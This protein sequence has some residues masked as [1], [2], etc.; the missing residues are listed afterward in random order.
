MESENNNHA[1]ILK[2]IVPNHYT[3]IEFKFGKDWAIFWL[4]YF[5]LR[6]INVFLQGQIWGVRKR[7]IPIIF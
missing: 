5:F 3:F 2:L 7:K 6:E 4:R 1:S